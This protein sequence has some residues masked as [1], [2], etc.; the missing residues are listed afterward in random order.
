MDGA[1][2]GEALAS[3]VKWF[4][5]CGHNRYIISGPFDGRTEVMPES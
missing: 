1:E 2:G 5:L 3:M 4:F